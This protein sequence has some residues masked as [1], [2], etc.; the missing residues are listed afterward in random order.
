MSSARIK[1]T[2]GCAA[3]ASEEVRAAAETSA[4]RLSNFIIYVGI[5]FVISGKVKEKI[6]PVNAPPHPNG[7]LVIFW[8]Y[9]DK[10]EPPVC[11]DPPNFVSSAPATD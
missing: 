9:L 4:A 7:G 10:I 11:P 2:L 1:T 5:R 6:G 3:Q 8:P